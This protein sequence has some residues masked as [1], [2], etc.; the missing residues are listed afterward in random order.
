MRILIAEDEKSLRLALEDEL[1]EAGFKVEVASSGEEAIA[2]LAA[3]EYDLVVCDLIMDGIGGK[4]VLD[5]VKARHPG[6]AFVLMTAHATIQSAIEI[7][8]RGAMDY[9]RKPFEIEE[10]L[11]IISQVKETIRVRGKAAGSA[12]AWPGSRSF[13]NMFGRSRAIRETFQLASVVAGTDAAVMIIGE[14]GTGKNMLAEAIHYESNRR[15]H[16]YIT[17]S[18]AALSRE[19]LESELFGHEKGAFTGSAR[20]RKG[21]FELAHKGT[22][23]LNEVDDIPMETQGRLLNFIQTGKFERVGGEDTLHTDVRIIAATKKDLLKQ[24]ERG[25]FRQDLY[26]RLNVL[27]IRLPPLRERPEDVP[28]LVEFFLRKY[29]LD[30]KLSVSPE[31]MDILKGYPWEGNVR[32]LEQVVERLVLLNRDGAIDRSALPAAILESAE[33]APGFGWG[34][35]SLPDYMDRMEESLLKD[36]LCKCG[37]NKRDTAALLKIPLPTLKSKLAKFHL[38]KSEE[39]DNGEVL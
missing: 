11:K 5:H 1:R 8:K 38:G 36:A 15:N 29:S 34:R 12:E 22:L 25:L 14:T 13:G 20:Q 2:K 32:E 6:T 24:V 21:R 18:C 7:L 35:S 17:V 3:A 31:I 27:Q 30:R 9:L 4:E 23:F 10:L 33:H 16:A 19:L 39:G 26:Y 37:G 28:M